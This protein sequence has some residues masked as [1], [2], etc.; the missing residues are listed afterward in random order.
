MSSFDPF[1]SSGLGR[2]RFQ[3]VHAIGLSSGLI[4]WKGFRFSHIDTILPGGEC[5][6]AR[7]D[8]VKARG[9]PIP[10]GVEIRP[11]DYLWNCWD[12]VV[13][14]ELP[15]LPVIEERW[16]EWLRLQE[17]KPY[18][19]WRIL[20]IALGANHIWRDDGMWFCSEMAERSLEPD[21]SGY[22]ESFS[23]IPDNRVDPG[24]F[25][26]GASLMRDAKLNVRKG[27]FD[28]LPIRSRAAA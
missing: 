19:R 7:S 22:R 13:E 24:V 8:R 12:L 16:L 11:R 10:A 4:A 17:H 20:E 15:C 2:L 5:F 14:V 9:E 3:G 1:R 23:A 28:Y 21:T 27:V 25:M 26:F 18:D 6:G